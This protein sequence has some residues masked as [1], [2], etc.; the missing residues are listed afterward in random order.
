MWSGCTQA[1]DVLHTPNTATGNARR[2][3]GPHAK[4]EKLLTL[5]QCK[6]TKCLPEA[7]RDS[8][9]AKT[10]CFGPTLK[11]LYLNVEKNDK[12]SRWNGIL[13]GAGG[14]MR[15]YAKSQVVMSFWVQYAVLQ[16]FSCAITCNI[17]LYKPHFWPKLP[18][19]RVVFF[20]HPSS[21][22]A[23]KTRDFV[24]YW[25]FMDCDNHH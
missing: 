6:H 2:R 23:F 24:P 15:G 7:Q 25:Q 11:K 21:I 17:L 4:K 20:H 10:L 18:I 16:Y 13:A 12:R 9:N 19:S 1:S 14:A 8:Y 5:S 22:W 3:Q